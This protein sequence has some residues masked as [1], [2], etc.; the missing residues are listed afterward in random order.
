MPGRIL[1]ADE[2]DAVRSVAV[3]LFRQRG[4][5]VLTASGGPEAWEIVK[6]GKIDLAVVNSSLVGMDGYTISKLIKEDSTLA[7]TGIILMLPQSEIVNQHQLIIAQPDGTLT[8]P[9]SP[10]DLLAKAGDILGEDL[11]PKQEDGSKTMSNSVSE[12]VMGDE[13]TAR[14]I[15]FESIFA[16]DEKNKAVEDIHLSDV[17]D[18]EKKLESGEDSQISEI[19]FDEDKEGMEM[20]DK[21]TR[22]PAEEDSIRLAHD[23]YGLEEPFEPPEVEVPH[24]YNW[25]IREMKNEISAKPKEPAKTEAK[26]TAPPAKSQTDKT[27]TGHFTVE[28]IGSSKMEMPGEKQQNQEAMGFANTLM[29]SGPEVPEIDD[30]DADV[31]LA[32]AEKLLIKELARRIAEKLMQKI[33]RKDLHNILEEVLSELKK[34]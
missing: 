24:D 2:S 17:L 4:F 14:E 27:P 22:M 21:K 29:D 25:F 15:D 31:K 8:K 10:P 5:E 7:N 11:T 19:S 34:Y 30:S 23:Q 3:S 33:S 16:D 20:S 6:S 18:E 26:P 28:E 32:L 12:M 9:F 1:I 13:R